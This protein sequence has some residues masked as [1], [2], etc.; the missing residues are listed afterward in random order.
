MVPEVPTGSRVIACE[1]DQYHGPGRGLRRGGEGDPAKTKSGLRTVEYRERFVGRQR[2]IAEDI[3]DLLA[4][5]RLAR[6]PIRRRSRALDSASASGR[7][8]AML[9]R[10][11]H[12]PLATRLRFRAAPSLATVFSLLELRDSPQ[13]LAHQNGSRGVL[14]EDV[15][16]DA[17][18]R[19]IPFA[20]SM[21]GRR[22][23]P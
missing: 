10:P 22:A 14:E 16:A 19:V 9:F 11:S 2:R 8:S 4:P 1:A 12:L 5:K 20:F 3:G 13:H 23:A 6:L 7:V 18:M 17:A 21:R 15:G